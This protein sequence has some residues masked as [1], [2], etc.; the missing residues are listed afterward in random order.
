MKTIELILEIIGYIVI[1]LVVLWFIVLII[2]YYCSPSIIKTF[3]KETFND[4]DVKQTEDS[5]YIS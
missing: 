2:L 1:V 3:K 4:I 5:E